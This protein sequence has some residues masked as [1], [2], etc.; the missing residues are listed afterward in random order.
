MVLGADAAHWS[1]RSVVPR[2]AATLERRLALRR[3]SKS[4]A[5]PTLV[6]GT[7]LAGSGASAATPSFVV[8]G[9]SAIGTFGVKTDG[10][11]AGAIR[12]FG[13]PRLRRDRQACLA[14]WPAHGLTMNL[15]NLGGLDPCRPSSGR[16]SRAIVRGTRWRTDRGLRVGMPLSAIRASYPRAGFHRGSRPYWPS[17]WWLVTRREPFGGSGV[18]PGLLAVVAGGRV[19]TLHVRYPA[20]GD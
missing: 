15:Y 2:A 5:L 9:D 14:T 6:L 18:Y 11:L 10:S 1:H 13:T 12:A 3:R 8:R 19:A 16:F 20:G 17:G 4:L 7:L